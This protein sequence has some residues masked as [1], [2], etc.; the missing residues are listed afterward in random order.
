M[1]YIVMETQTTGGTTAIVTPVIF[2]DRDQ[3]ESKYHLIL[4]SAAVSQIEEHTAMILTQDGR[5]VR[6]ECYRHY[7][8]P[9]P[10]ETIE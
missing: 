2:N 5:V 10:E 6:S 7:T 9:E 1:N 8:E 3:A 4:T